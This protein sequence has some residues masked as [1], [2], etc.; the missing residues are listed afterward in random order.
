MFYNMSVGNKLLMLV[1]FLEKIRNICYDITMAEG[2]GYAVYI[3]EIERMWDDMKIALTAKND[4]VYLLIKDFT[5][6]GIMSEKI[7]RYNAKYHDV[8]YIAE[9][10]L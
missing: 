8:D 9:R 5:T 10:I 6:K 7:A 1:D 4:S 2:V 3:R